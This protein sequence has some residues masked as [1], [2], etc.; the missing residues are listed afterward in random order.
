MN[1]AAIDL[2]SNSVLLTVI[3]SDNRVLHD[4]ARVVGLGQGLG[5]G[6]SFDPDRV[7]HTLS[8]LADYAQTAS[9]Y[10]ILPENVRLGGT[11]AT[12]R[13]RDIEAF[14]QRIAVETGLLLQV[15][16]GAEEARLS[17]HGAISDR[18]GEQL[19][20]IDLG[21]G[22]TEVITGTPQ[23][24]TS[25]VSLELGSARLT[26]RFLG[27]GRVET[28]N[29]DTLREFVKQT[30]SSQVSGTATTAIAVAGTATTLAAIDLQLPHWDSSRVHGHSLHITA[31]E[32]IANE[33]LALDAQGRRS[34]AHISPE[35]GDFLA[36]G[37]LV[38]QAVLEHWGLQATTVSIRGLRFG[39]LDAP[40]WSEKP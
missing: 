13:A 1:R 8:A 38:I 7:A 12:R 39:I 4:E 22:S 18:A 31:L 23:A 32:N 5:D 6:G 19:A 2:G 11:S 29:A 40:N 30:V 34:L 20:V 35:R 16:S 26:E 33:L 37:A 14:S 3:D 9:E 17:W 27:L 21:G 28:A 10:G 24:I 15:I 36:A 25:R